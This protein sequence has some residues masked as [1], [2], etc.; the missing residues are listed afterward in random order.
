MFF[1]PYKFRGQLVG[2][3]AMGAGFQASRL[4]QNVSMKFGEY[5]MIVIKNMCQKWPSKDS[6][7]I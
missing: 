7:R 3:L 5:N 6:E 4:L 2:R 1:A